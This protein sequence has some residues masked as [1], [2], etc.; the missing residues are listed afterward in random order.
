MSCWNQREKPIGLGE[1]CNPHR[2]KYEVPCQ[3]EGE[4]LAQVEVEHLYFVLGCISLHREQD[5]A[6]PI[7]SLRKTNNRKI[8]YDAVV[9]N[10]YL[11]FV[12]HMDWS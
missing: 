10:Y 12:R 11:I 1:K 6:P 2:D 7:S 3:I 5:P 4:T 9:D 8:V